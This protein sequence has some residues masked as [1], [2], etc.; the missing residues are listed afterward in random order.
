MAQSGK[1]AKGVQHEDAVST[2]LSLVQARQGRRAPLCL[3][4]NLERGGGRSWSRHRVRAWMCPAVRR[5]VT[6]SGTGD[7]LPPHSRTAV[8]GRKP[9][10]CWRPGSWRRDRGGLNCR[11]ACWSQTTICRAACALPLCAE[12]VPPVGTNLPGTEPTSRLLPMVRDADHRFG[13]NQQHWD[14]SGLVIAT[15]PHNIDVTV[16]MDAALWSVSLSAIWMKA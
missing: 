2:P 9:G 6:A 3:P 14:K 12:R 15:Q 5:P 10:T 13:P 1:C 8:A 7:P 16:P 4:A 11:F